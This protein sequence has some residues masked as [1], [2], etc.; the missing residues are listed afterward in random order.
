MVANV[1]VACPGLHRRECGGGDGFIIVVS[2]GPRGDM[3]DSGSVTEKRE[4]QLFLRLQMG[5][6]GSLIIFEF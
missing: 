1:H 4:G 2:G 6:G 5:G 3:V